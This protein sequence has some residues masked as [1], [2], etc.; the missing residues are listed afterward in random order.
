MKEG[1][2]WPHLPEP[3]RGK[4][5]PRAGEGNQNCPG[6]LSLPDYSPMEDESREQYAS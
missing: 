1:R 2:V 6:L 5:W 3:C 4:S